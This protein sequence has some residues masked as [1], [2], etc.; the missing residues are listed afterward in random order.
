VDDP[1]LVHPRPAFIAAI[2]GPGDQ[3]Q[4]VGWMAL[5]QDRADAQEPDRGIVVE[6]PWQ[7]RQPKDRVQF[8]AEIGRTS[9]FRDSSDGRSAT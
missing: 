1:V 5:I 4:R 8:I 7:Q 6:K 9:L 2:T 3:F